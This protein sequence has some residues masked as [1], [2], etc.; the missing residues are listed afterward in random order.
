MRKHII[1]TAFSLSTLLIASSVDAAPRSQQVQIEARI[2]PLGRT[3]M[4]ECIKPSTG[5]LTWW[6]QTAGRVYAQD[7]ISQT[8]SPILP[9]EDRTFPKS[10]DLYLLRSGQ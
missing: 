10:Y 6:S 3:F 2:C 5:Q 9:R 8:A 4:N 7:S 1:A